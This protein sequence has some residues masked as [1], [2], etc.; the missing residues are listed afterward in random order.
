MLVVKAN[1]FLFPRPDGVDLPD[2]EWRHGLHGGA[3]ETAM[4]LHLRPDLVRASQMTESRSLGEELEGSLRHL[5]P[6]GD[7]ASF[8]WLVGDLNL[9][10]VTG[11]A[12]LADAGKGERLVAHYGQ[13][14]AH[15]IRDAR[16]FPLKQLS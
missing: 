1:Y 12:R 6:D 5:S 4:M 9:S 16:T 3:V 8:S 15:V 13:A 10:G 7:A 11:D 2:S 14:L